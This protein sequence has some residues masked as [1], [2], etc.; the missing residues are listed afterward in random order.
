[1]SDLKSTHLKFCKGKIEKQDEKLNT[2]WPK[3]PKFGNLGL[4]F[5]QTSVRFE[6]STFEIGYMQNFVM[7]REL[8]L[9]GPKFSNFGT[10]A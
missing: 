4:K 8:I 7:V 6:I 1:M 5:S 10:W 3:M 9:F 2:F